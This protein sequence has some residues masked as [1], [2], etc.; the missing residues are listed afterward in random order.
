MRVC[1]FPQNLYLTDVELTPD[2]QVVAGEVI[3]GGW[4]FRSNGVT[5]FAYRGYDHNRLYP[6]THHPAQPQRVV[7]VAG[8]SRDYNETLFW[9]EQQPAY[10]G[11]VDEMKA[12]YDIAPVERL[13]H[14][15]DMDDDIAF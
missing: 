13:A 8:F 6:V 3:N 10:A 14:F 9:A 5:D 12:Q 7:P 4:F 15:K 1:I 11:T 2:G